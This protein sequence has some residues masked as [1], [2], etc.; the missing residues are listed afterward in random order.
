[1]SVAERRVLTLTACR[2][3]LEG[4]WVLGGAS[5]VL[6]T[7]L[8]IPKECHH[9][10][11]HRFFSAAR[12]CPRQVGLVLAELVVSGLLPEVAPVTVVVDDTLVPSSRQEGPHCGLVPRRFSGRAGEAGVRQ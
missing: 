7:A 11:A 2:V 8:S 9:A 5:A 4:L 12:C 3:D 1:V 6:S 10:R